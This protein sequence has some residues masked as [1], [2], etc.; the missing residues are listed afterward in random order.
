MEIYT[1]AVVV[2]LVVALIMLALKVKEMSEIFD[3][4]YEKTHVRIKWVQ[5]D[6][7]KLRK[8]FTN[9]LEVI[10]EVFETIGK[11]FGKGFK[12]VRVVS[13]GEYG[14]EE[15]ITQFELIDLPKVKKNK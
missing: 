7:D 8:D 15:I 3:R 1:A 4:H 6:V 11:E 13:L 10:A 12:E 5:E 2:I 9:F 14:E